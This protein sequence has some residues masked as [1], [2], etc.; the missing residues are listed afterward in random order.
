MR[1]FLAL[2]LCVAAPLFAQRTWTVD[3]TNRPGTDF[4]DLPPAVVAAA[5]GDTIIVRVGAY[6]SSTI[7]NGI[8]LL[9]QG[10][11]QITSLTLD[12]LPSQQELVVKG[13]SLSQFAVQNCLGR[14]H[15]ESLVVV[16]FL[17]STSIRNCRAVN[18]AN[19]TLWSTTIAGSLVSLSNTTLT[20][21]VGSLSAV[22]INASDVYLSGCTVVGSAADCRFA[23][24]P[25]GVGLAV[26][27]SRITLARPNTVRAGAPDPL[28]TSRPPTPGI[29]ADATSR[30]DLDPTAVVTGTDGGPPVRG[31]VPFFATLPG[32]TARGAASGATMSTELTG[33][34]SAPA[35]VLASLTSFDQMLPFGRIWLDQATVFTVQTAAMPANGR[36]TNQIPLGPFYPFG[37]P[38]AFQGAVLDAGQLRI[39]TPSVAVLW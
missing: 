20:P 18:I 14:V 27:S 30:I 19:S 16:P 3:R 31:V 28:C 34:A 23:A 24:F 1:G 11:V 6:T 39:S 25:P 22:S 4:T 15:L 36:L 7:R 13:L 5:P 29:D 33:P 17:G 2:Y 9:A 10:L 38:L 37:L 26:R 8:R 32:L 12:S 35:T 21:G